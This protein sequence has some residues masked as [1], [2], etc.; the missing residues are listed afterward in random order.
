MYGE[1]HR[2]GCRHLPSRQREYDKQAVSRLESS[3]V[4]RRC[5]GVQARAAAADVEDRLEAAQ[6]TLH[7]PEPRLVYREHY[8]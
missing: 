5:V 1:E 4:M 2:V 6:V 3:R 8:A 7:E